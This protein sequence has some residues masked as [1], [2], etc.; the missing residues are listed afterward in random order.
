MVADALPGPSN[1]RDFGGFVGAHGRIVSGRF[2]R[3]AAPASIGESAQAKLDAAGIA[4]VIDLRGVEERRRA[5]FSSETSVVSAPVEPATSGRIKAALDDG[6][7]THSGLRDLMIESYRG[8][9]QDNAPAFGAAIEALVEA[10]EPTLVHCTAGKDRTG[11]IV[12]VLQH[13]LGA[14][15]DHILDDYR[16]TNID[17]DRASVAGH[18]TLAA[19]LSEA[20]LIAD[21]DYLAAAFEEIDRRD[22]SVEAFIDR[23]TRGRVTPSRLARFV[24]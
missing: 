4:L 20:V 13:A 15:S 3:S 14:S 10:S 21:P 9:V 6:S 23:A 12:A 8:Y 11:F 5:L 19:P 22:G 18:L 17:W 7:L 16:Q 1:F 24:A 2:Y